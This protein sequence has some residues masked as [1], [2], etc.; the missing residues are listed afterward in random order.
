MDLQQSDNIRWSQI[1]SELALKNIDWF[2]SRGYSL[3]QNKD[4]YYITHPQDGQKD[5]DSIWQ[6][7]QFVESMEAQSEVKEMKH[8]CKRTELKWN[9]EPVCDGEEV[10][11]EGTC[12]VCGK[13]YEQVFSE[14]QGLWD[15]EIEDYVFI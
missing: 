11:F 1:M 6:A 5:F 10:S 4:R 12:P 3:E 14:N 7:Q 2:K 8:E 13:V 9:T 15:R